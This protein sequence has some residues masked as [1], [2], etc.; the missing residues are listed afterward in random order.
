MLLLT[1][2]DG[3]NILVN[4]EAIKYVEANPD[5]RIL[6]L[7]GEFL[8]VRESMDAIQ[9]SVLKLKISILSRSQHPDS[10]QE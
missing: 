2:L 10:T 6:F 7:N 9:E 3:S 1:K 8:I 5:T 4:L